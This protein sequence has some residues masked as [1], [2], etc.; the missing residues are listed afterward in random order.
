MAEFNI[1]VV[2]D[3]EERAGMRKKLEE[4]GLRKAVEEHC[5]E[6]WDT[7]EGLSYL[8]VMGV[9]ESLCNILTLIE[10]DKEQLY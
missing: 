6:I 7:V 3:E 9:A 4:V 2:D 10:L 5:N 8:A 1:K